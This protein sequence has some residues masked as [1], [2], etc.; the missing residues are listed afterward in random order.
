MVRH[1]LLYP[2]QADDGCA[3]LPGLVVR[4]GIGGAGVDGLRVVAVVA[5][6]VAIVGTVYHQSLLGMGNFTLSPVER[7]GF[8]LV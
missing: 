5:S 4:S 3:G 1:P 2:G 8:T 6:D 7:T